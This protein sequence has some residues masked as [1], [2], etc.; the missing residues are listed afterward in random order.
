MVDEKLIRLVTERVIEKIREYN[1]YKIPIGVSNRH[2]HVTKEDLEILYGPGCELTKK[3]DL[4]QPGQFAANETVTI[5]GPKGEF[6]NVRILG[7]VRSKSQVEISKTDSFRLGIRPPVRESGDLS[8]TP[9]IELVGP[10]GTV[11]LT[12]GAI[13]ALRHIHMTLAQAEAMGV[14]DKDIVEV[15]TFGERH[16]VFGDVLVRVSDKFSLEMHVDIDEA[17]ACALK[18]NDYVILKRPQGR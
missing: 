15:E 13:V 11:A 2:V 18:N 5:R 3:G 12:E 1:T 8:G 9:G 6:K 10:K 4:K 7:P 16:G 14:K 17:N